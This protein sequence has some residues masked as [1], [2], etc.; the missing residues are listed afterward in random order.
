VRIGENDDDIE[1][2]CGGYADHRL[3]VERDIVFE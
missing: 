1:R 2:D 3:F